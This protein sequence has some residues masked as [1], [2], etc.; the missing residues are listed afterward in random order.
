M[1]GLSQ[2]ELSKK[3]GVPQQTISM[4]ESELRIPRVDNAIALSSALGKTVE[5][6]FGKAEQLKRE[7]C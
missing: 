6:V 4:I 2:Q 7:A 3:S 5:E 1:A